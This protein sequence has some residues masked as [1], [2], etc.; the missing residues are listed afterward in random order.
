MVDKNFL[1]KAVNSISDLEFTESDVQDIFDKVSIILDDDLNK[2]LLNIIERCDI[3]QEDDLGTIM[4]KFVD[5]Y[6][7][8]MTETQVFFNRIINN[9]N[10][11]DYIQDLL[12]EKLI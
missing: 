6:N 11:V 10:I 7:G 3:R 5:G 12:L 1:K 9:N 2:L 8:L 4:E